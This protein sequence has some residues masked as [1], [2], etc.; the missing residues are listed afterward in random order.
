MLLCSLLIVANVGPVVDE[1]ITL[2]LLGTPR[3]VGTLDKFKVQIWMVE[4]ALSAFAYRTRLWL[5]D[6]GHWTLV[7]RP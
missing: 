5:L 3:R 7:T 4:N 1:R 6:F 2:S